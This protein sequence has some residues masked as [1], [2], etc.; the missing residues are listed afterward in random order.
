MSLTP[1]DSRLGICALF[2]RGQTSLRFERNKNEILITNGDRPF[3][4]GQ[5]DST[6]IVPVRHQ[7]ELL[8]HIPRNHGGQEVFLKWSARGKNDREI[9]QNVTRDI[10]CQWRI[11]PN[12]KARKTST[13]KQKLCIG[14]LRHD[15]TNNFKSFAVGF[16]IEAS[17]SVRVRSSI[18][19][20]E[21]SPAQVVER[22]FE[23]IPPKKKRYS[24][25]AL[26]HD[27][28]G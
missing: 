22:A 15:V 13:S 12:F 10:K 23:K 20:N 27:T 11:S 5:W 14:V 19:N 18:H 4:S 3:L 28:S 24:Q 25:K 17:N 8:H 26:R 2:E 9:V 6:V 7:R 21:A 1:P 16:N